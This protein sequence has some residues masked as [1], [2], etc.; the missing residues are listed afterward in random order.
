MS[1]EMP[2]N[3]SRMAIGTAGKIIRAPSV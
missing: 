1:P 3:G 2:L